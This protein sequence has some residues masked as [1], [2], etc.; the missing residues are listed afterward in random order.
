MEMGGKEM[1]ARAD[2]RLALR[3]LENP[4]RFFK[5]GV[6]HL[7]KQVYVGIGE[8]TEMNCSDYFEEG[9]DEL[10]KAIN[11]KTIGEKLP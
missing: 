10:H 8:G 5:E 9:V 3:K 2:V 1:I 4:E 7:C 11:G 6:Y